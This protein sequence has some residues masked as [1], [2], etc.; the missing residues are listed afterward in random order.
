ML[1]YRND[2]CMVFHRS[3]NIQIEKKTIDQQKRRLTMDLLRYVREFACDI[4][5][6]SFERM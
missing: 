3:V 4:L 6:H 5:V 2:I 1:Y